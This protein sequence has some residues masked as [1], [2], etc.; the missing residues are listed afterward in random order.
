MTTEP[1]EH[2]EPSAVSS[3]V[4]ETLAG[5]PRVVSLV[6]LAFGLVVGWTGCLVAHFLTTSKLEVFRQA[7]SDAPPLT[8]IY[9]A[10]SELVFAVPFLIWLAGMAVTRACKRRPHVAREFGTVSIVFGVVWSLGA[11]LVYHNMSSLSS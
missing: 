8:R 2:R 4:N 1:V 5:K 9:V 11:L 7:L 10:T 6:R 3:G